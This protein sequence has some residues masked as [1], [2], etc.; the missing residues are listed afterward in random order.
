MPLIRD[1]FVAPGVRLAVWRIT[2][3]VDD[4]AAPAHVD[5]WAM[6]SEARKLE[7]LAVY[8]MLRHMTGRADLLISHDEAGRPLVPGWTLSISHTKGWAALILSGTRAVAVDIEYMSDRVERV[9]HRFLR[10]DEEKGNT[11]H[12]LVSWSAKE[13]VYKFLHAER[14]LFWDMRLGAFVVSDKGMVEVEDLKRLNVV[15]V[16]FELNADYVLTYAVE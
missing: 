14:L 10:P 7:V 13:T 12:Q 6:Q 2:E 16:R 1:E 5:L 4:F 3:H 8:A 15:K 9:A 11:A